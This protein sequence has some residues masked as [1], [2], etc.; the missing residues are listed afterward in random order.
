M[1]RKLTQVKVKVMPLI[2]IDDN[3]EGI[4]GTPVEKH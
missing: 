4:H 2:K 3:M 1:L